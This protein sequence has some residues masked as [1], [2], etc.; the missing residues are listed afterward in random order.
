MIDAT[1]IPLA[2]LKKEPFSGSHQGMRYYFQIQE[3]KESFQVTI[4]P[5]P[6][7]LPNTPKEQQTTRIFPLST[8]GMQEAIDWLWEEYKTK[9]EVWQT[10]L[11]ER[12]RTVFQAE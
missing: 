12:M 1:L 4:Y 3:D 11:Q 5:E 10:A 7:S 6:W 8:D 2:G 9:K